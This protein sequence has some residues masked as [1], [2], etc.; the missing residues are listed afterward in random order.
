MT[1]HL[2]DIGNR[3]KRLQVRHHRAIEA[4][5][6]PLGISTVQWDALR[7]WEDHPAASLHDLARLTYQTDQSF[8]GLA[9]RMIERGLIERVSAPGRA[10][11]HRITDKGHALRTA[12]DDI[13]EGVLATSF[14]SLTPAEISSFD[15]LL[16]KI[17]PPP[18]SIPGSPAAMTQK[19]NGPGVSG[20][21]DL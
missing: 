16:V 17:L 21:S 3:V 15:A 9:G 13:V 12:A 11:R 5:L 19:V 10:V 2:R 14:G 1:E 20:R 4:A 7:K 18:P 6:A 8:G